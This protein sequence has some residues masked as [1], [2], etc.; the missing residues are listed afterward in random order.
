[1]GLWLD[2]GLFHHSFL[3]GHLGCFH[4]LAFVNNVV[5]NKVVQ[6]SSQVSVGLLVLI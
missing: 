3:S 1:M 2:R 6:I 5:V 4:F